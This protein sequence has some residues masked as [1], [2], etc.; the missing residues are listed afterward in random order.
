MFAA[1]VSSHYFQVILEEEGS[2]TVFLIIN[3][4]STL[5]FPRVN[6]VSMLANIN[7]ELISYFQELVI[8]QYL[9]ILGTSQC[10]TPKS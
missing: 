1:L 7:D 8:E 10:Y 9:Q 6:D 5:I 4:R 3:D 2:S